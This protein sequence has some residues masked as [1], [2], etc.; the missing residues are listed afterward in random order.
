MSM[1][2][3][4]LVP[5]DGS[6]LSEASLGAARL[7]ATKFDSTV[8]L[9]HV[10]E[11]GAPP[12]VHQERHLTGAEEAETYLAEVAKRAFPS[13]IRVERH[14]HAEPAVDVARSIVAHA[15]AEF[16]PDL[17]VTCTHGRSGMRDL[18]FG[19][20]AQQ[21]VAQGKTPL[22]LIRPDSPDFRVTGILVPLDPDSLHD[23]GLKP[24]EVLAKAFHA[25][26]VL[27]SVVP[28]YA[29]LTG[30]QAATSSLM[31]ATAQAL[32]DLTEEHAL[33]HLHEHLE[34]LRGRGIACSATVVRGEPAAA[35]VKTAEGSAFD[36]IILS[37]HGK[38]GLGAFWSKSV[39]PKIVQGTKTPLLLIPLE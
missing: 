4:I 14:V 22:L 7:L 16:Q 20:I 17:I 38:K 23:D 5:L 36:L 39:A 1:F 26:L 32:L 9:L 33:D 13:S 29:T 18:L 27:A 35:I 28:T 10:V 25:E 3:S 31:P 15:T 34:A 2:R 11:E 6:A 24:A 37:T 8:I 19:S 12:E 30:E 21:I